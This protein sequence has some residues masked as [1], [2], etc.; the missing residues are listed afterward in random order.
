MYACF[1]PK[2]FGLITEVAAIAI[3]AIERSLRPN[4]PFYGG[5]SPVRELL[6]TVNTAIS[7]SGCQN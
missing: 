6:V 7:A 4:W 2:I 1:G 3:T 5:T